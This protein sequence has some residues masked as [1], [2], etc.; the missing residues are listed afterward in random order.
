M[1]NALSD[2]RYRRELALFRHVGQP[3]GRPIHP[4]RGNARALGRGSGIFGIVTTQFVELHLPHV[5]MDLSAPVEPPAYLNGPMWP[6]ALHDITDEGLREMFG[7][8]GHDPQD[9][10]KS[11]ATRWEDFD[12]RM[13]FIASFFRA[14]QRDPSLASDPSTDPSA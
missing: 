12:E 7:R 11:G 9:P 5:S 13:G 6:T 1:F 2:G 8:I 4:R 3:N 14:Y 10:S